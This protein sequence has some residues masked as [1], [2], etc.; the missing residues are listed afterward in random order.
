MTISDV[1]L[2]VSN[3]LVCSDQFH[4]N[5]KQ[6]HDNN[7]V[8]IFN[9]IK[10]YIRNYFSMFVNVMMIKIVV[11]Q[12]LNNVM[13]LNIVNKFV[14]IQFFLVDQGL[15]SLRKTSSVILFFCCYSKFKNKSIFPTLI[16]HMDSTCYCHSCSS[17]YCYYY[18]DAG[19]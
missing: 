14:M 5:C 3:A 16:N 7:Q 11:L 15:S 1:C 13:S 19:L 9:E 6:T 17:F 12:W 4:L 10:I 2:N 18:H 8:I